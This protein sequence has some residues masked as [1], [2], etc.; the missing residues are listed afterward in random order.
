MNWINT[1]INIK[2]LS[3]AYK[4]AAKP[5]VAHKLLVL[6]KEVYGVVNGMTITS[7]LLSYIDYKDR[8]KT[9]SVVSQSKGQET[10]ATLL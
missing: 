1:T 10:R 2:V 3:G 6:Y 5:S 8:V 7:K 9:P 4:P